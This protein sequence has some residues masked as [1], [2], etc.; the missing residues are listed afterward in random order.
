M[1]T[2]NTTRIL[3]IRRRLA[4]TV[5][6]ALAGPVAS[7][8]TNVTLP[9]HVPPRV[10]AATR[11][12]SVAA[13]ETIRLSL[14]V[15]L[16]DALLK[17]TLDQLYGPNAPAQKHFLT[18]AE[19]AQKF[20]LAAKREQLKQ[21]AQ[22]HGMTVNAAEDR[23]DSMVV[24]VLGNAGTIEQTFG[25]QL[26]RYRDA[27]GQVFRAHDSDPVIPSSIEAHLSAILGLSDIPGVFHTNLQASAIAS[28]PGSGSLS[29]SAPGGGLGPSDI[30]TLYTLPTTVTAGA[31]Q[32]V[33]VFELSP[34]NPSDVAAY[35][36]R[37]NL[38]NVPLTVI[39]LDGFSSTCGS[40]GCAG[41]DT[42]EVD[43]DTE[44]IAG[45][46]PGL[47]RIL[48]YDGPNSL[49]GALDIYN[50]IATD[51]LAPVV[52]T[53]WTIGESSGGSSLL[54]SENQIFQ[55][56]AI[57]GQAIFSASGDGGGYAES[58]QPQDP[59]S[60]PFVTA[61]GGTS[62]S[63]TLQAPV[64]TAWSGSGGGVSTYWPLPGYQAGL[65][66][67]ASQ[68]FRNVP[69]VALNA[70]PNSPYAVYVNGSW[71]TIGGTSA[72][73]PLW[74]VLT[75][76]I[77]Q[78]RAASGMPALGFA[79]PALYQLATSSQ[80]GD[81]Y[82]DITAGNNEIYSAA[83]GYDN[84]TGW[85][86]Y[87]GMALL[88]ATSQANA[89]V[90]IYSPAAGQYLVNSF[91][92]SGSATAPAF[93]SYRLE[94]GAGTN[95]SAFSLI[96]SV[97][98]T[99][100]T[101]GVL[102]TWNTS[103]L[104]SGI[105]T[106]RL[107]LANTSSQTTSVTT[108][109]LYIDSSPPTAPAQ[110]TLVA[111]S[112]TALSLSWTAATD[113]FS[114]AGYRIDL[115]NSA[116]FSS[117][118]PGYQNFDAHSATTLAISSLS[119]DTTYY[120]RV[121]A[122]D[123]AG[124]VSPNSPVAQ[125]TT[126]LPVAGV[127]V[128]DPVLLAPACLSTGSVCDSGGLLNGRGNL[129]G[130]GAEPNQPNTL[131]NSCAD[132]SGGAY[133]VD[134]SNDHLTV[135]TLNGQPF[136]PGAT[137]QVN[138]TVWA[139]A[140]FSADSLD[141]YYT[142]NANS[143]AWTWMT[144][145]KPT[146]SGPQVLSTAFTLSNGSLQAVRAIFRYGNGKPAACTT[147]GYDD[148]DDLAF[149]VGSTAPP[150]PAPVINSPANATATAGSAFSYAI[151]AS[152]SPTRFSATGLPAGLSINT[153]TGL[154]SGTPQSAGTSTIA[155]GAANAGGTG[156]ATLILTINAAAIP[157]PVITSPLSASG[158]VGSNFSYNITASN[159]PTSYNATGLPSGLGIN[160]VT[161]SISG[162]P[163]SAGVFHVT[164]TASNAGG[165]GAASLTL[166]ISPA[167]APSVPVAAFTVT[168]A[169]GSA[170]VTVT[171]D[172]S[173]STG[174]NLTYA[175]NFGDHASGY[176]PVINHTYTQPGTYGITL[177]VTNSLGT[178]HTRNLVV[179]SGN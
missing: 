154:I 144:T 132:G 94:Y 23:P 11:L 120:A 33:A 59:A 68:Q 72:A 153:A 124:N 98:T 166:T 58:V 175:W 155:L 105:Y 104:P 2:S 110:V 56:M 140:A 179:V 133:H 82:R 163:G 53:S 118:V 170:P 48:V 123:G 100:V 10:L 130:G 151:T 148:H 138:A 127:A 29:G 38:P 7:A 101:F 178:S 39:D 128:Y 4:A 15:R 147:G 76:M 121:R 106:L 176:G 85:G 161:G 43:L 18:S 49:Q 157:L 52:S 19:F 77:N 137:V 173:A 40:G 42:V 143:P 32:T 57:Q 28:S 47:S 20:E 174:G 45:I 74:A 1:S 162:I 87:Q 115:S 169:S 27:T 135:S 126:S 149:A 34:F 160:T 25:V 73:A 107:T 116:Q 51:N 92:I 103:G 78:Q 21:F 80:Y 114:V 24:S 81:L 108:S 75:A 65:A 35:S 13:D 89:S 125:A 90:S 141:I 93:A 117:Y 84:A 164:L 37:F 168:P 61:V 158:S 171:C 156:T 83:P 3:S 5:F 64:E 30:Q 150:P 112:S 14:A 9:G 109:P 146:A 88:N 67:A 71:L 55:R 122:Y 145:I 167:L 69:D 86:S 46:A 99:P 41:L 139:Y 60:Q 12:E 62:L 63:G 91:P 172:A 113:Y 50:Q 152:N 95:P 54:T 79:N 36:S 70:D 22:T 131:F 6:A 111:Q 102:G 8:Q 165:S 159:N 31:G 134:E 142:T 129:G 177:T 44:L 17:Q 97:Q 136:A 16:D 26:N 119:P 96:G 66:G